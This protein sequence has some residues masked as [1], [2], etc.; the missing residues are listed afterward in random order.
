MGKP[1]RPCKLPKV[2]NDVI[3]H[4]RAGATR[5]DAALL[6][7]IC[8]DSLRDW[9]AKGREDAEAGRKTPF[10]AFLQEVEQA[11]AEAR[12]R[13]VVTIQRAALEFGDWRAALEFLKRRDRE[14]WGDQSDAQSNNEP[15][16]LVLE[17]VGGRESESA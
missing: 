1:G 11:E 6:S 3:R 16:R 7:G 2:R 14:H 4:L 8:P 10:S 15:V 17:V 9:L 13:L 5:R 12:Q